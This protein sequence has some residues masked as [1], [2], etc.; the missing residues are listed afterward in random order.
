MTDAETEL[1][2]LFLAQQRRLSLELDGHPSFLARMVSCWPFRHRE[3]RGVTASVAH[4]LA[5]SY[6]EQA[7]E[8]A[9]D[10]FCGQYGLSPVSAIALDWRVA[11]RYMA[12]QLH[13]TT[14]LMNSRHQH[15]LSAPS[16]RQ[17]AGTV[18]PLA[19]EV[20]FRRARLLDSPEAA[21]SS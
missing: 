1:L 13:R 17:L 5:A 15:Y 11:L 16:Q 12:Q 4:R 8:D 3:D 9:M 2:K 10:R 6:I 20:A 19:A 14:S 18:L 21:A 7:I